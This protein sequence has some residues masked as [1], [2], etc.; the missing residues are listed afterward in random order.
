MRQLATVANVGASTLNNERVSST[1]T[2]IDSQSMCKKFSDH[3]V[4]K[5]T[6]IFHLQ[7][8]FKVGQITPLIKKP[9]AGSDVSE[10]SHYRPI[11]NLNTFGKILESLEHN[12]L[13]LHLS[14]S[15]NYNTSKAAYR[16]F[17]LDRNNNDQSS[18]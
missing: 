8:L 10:P 15:P 12:E 13:R 6:P 1:T 11:T 9:H 18:Q 17:A 3:F 7:K 2:K 14:T 16:T 4:S 5:L